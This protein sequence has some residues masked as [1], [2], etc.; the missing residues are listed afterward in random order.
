LHELGHAIGFSHEH[1]STNAGIVWNVE[2][3][4]A[5]FSGPP[6]SWSKAMIDSNIIEK[7]DPSQV[8]GS[9]WDPTSIMEYP[10]QPGLILAPKPYDKEGI[11]ENLSLSNFDVQWART[12]Y[13]PT[14]QAVPIAVMQLQTL[15]I[16]TG[17]QK[18]FTFSPGE[19]RDYTIGTVGQADCR[20][21]VFE[22]RDGEP[23]HLV[24]D[25]DSGTDTN[26]ALKTK[27]IKDRTYIIRV[28]V[29][30]ITKPA[31]SALLVY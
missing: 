10:F 13:P 22:Q 25:D 12:W 31:N 8:D 15:D 2:A 6:N 19:T 23:R 30:F 28:R 5:Y 27:L 24:S 9:I 7:L 18:D 1:Q 16:A 11:G 26:V 17:Q 3:V 20:V 4:Y 21:V 29:N 14:G